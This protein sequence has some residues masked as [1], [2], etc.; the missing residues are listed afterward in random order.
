MEGIQTPK[1][2]TTSEKTHPLA[3]ALTNPWCHASFLIP[4]LRA[5]NLDE[6]A[7]CIKTLDQN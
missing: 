1:L 5:A 3:T 7:E 4:P 6:K 2:S